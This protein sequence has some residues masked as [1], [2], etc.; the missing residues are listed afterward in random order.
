MVYYINLPRGWWSGNYELYKNQID[1]RIQYWYKN[2]ENNKLKRF[3]D[4]LV[5]NNLITNKITNLK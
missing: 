4:K 3:I 5:K 2:G 1:D